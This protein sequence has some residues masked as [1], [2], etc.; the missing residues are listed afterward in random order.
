[1]MRRVLQIV[2][3]T[4]LLGGSA[5]Q[6]LSCVS[7]LEDSHPCCRVLATIKATTHAQALKKV[8]QTSLKGGS[9]GC[10]ATP[11]RPQETPVSSGTVQPNNAASIQHD[12]PI[13]STP[14]RS[15][16]ERPVRLGAPNDYS[17]PHFILYHA[18]L[19]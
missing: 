13:A 1:M 14:L 9:C 17:P 4:A 3:M 16:F 8:Q 7:Q 2:L 18:L 6:S 5:V 19:I 11:T 10:A 15:A 12:A